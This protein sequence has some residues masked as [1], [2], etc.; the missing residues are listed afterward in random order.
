VFEEQQQD[1]Q[2]PRRPSGLR[3]AAVA[4]ALMGAVVAGGY[5]IASAQTD[6]TPST[7]DTPGAQA[8][9]SDSTPQ[10]GPDGRGCDHGGEQAPSDSGS[11]S[12][13]SSSSGNATSL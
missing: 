3:R 10:P 11:S 4:T 7:Q 13:S 5:G 12:S 9:D 8:A 6:E 1:A 2:P